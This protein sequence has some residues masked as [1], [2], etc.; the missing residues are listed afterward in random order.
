MLKQLSAVSLLSL[1]IGISAVQAQP[2]GEA[3]RWLRYASI[4]PDGEAISFTHRGQ[5]FVV[6]AEGGL[7]VPISSES[8]YSHHPV[9]SRDSEKLAFASDISGDD[10]VYVTDFSGTLQRMTFSSAPEM[11]SS[12]SPDGKQ[13]LFEAVRLGDAEHSIQGALSSSPQLY[14]ASV[15]RGREV[16]VLPNQAGE[17]SWNSEIGADADCRP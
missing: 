10:D 15:D 17:A 3:P 4:S 5:I 2:S 8:G 6:A 14:A 7:A 11:P 12:F 1:M 9:W 13:I 16:L